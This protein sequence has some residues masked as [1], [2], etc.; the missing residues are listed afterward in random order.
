MNFGKVT[1]FLLFLA[2]SRNK[3]PFF[4]YNKQAEIDSDST[5]RCPKNG[6]HLTGAP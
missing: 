6:R 5:A 4:A 3:F 2:G 1:V